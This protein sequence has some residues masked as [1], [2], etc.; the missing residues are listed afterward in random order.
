MGAPNTGALLIQ[1]TLSPKFVAS[2]LNAFIDSILACLSQLAD[3]NLLLVF[4]RLIIKKERQIKLGDNSK[5]YS[6]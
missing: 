4:C 5:S 2:L 1:V 6:K 3:A